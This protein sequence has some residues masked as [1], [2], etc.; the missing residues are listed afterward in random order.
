MQKSKNTVIRKID[1][2]GRLVLPKDVRKQMDIHNGDLLELACT[3]ESLSITKY[4][5]IHEIGFLTEV[6]LNSV[7]DY[8]HVEG[9]LLEDYEIL[10]HPTLLSKKKLEKKLKEDDCISLPILLDSKEIGR[11]VF[12]SKEEKIREILS[13]VTLFLKNY[14]EEL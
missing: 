10:R 3:P 7:Y 5:S 6:L 14:L 2:L 4:S 11:I 8:Y 1:E 9:L 12:F 13:F